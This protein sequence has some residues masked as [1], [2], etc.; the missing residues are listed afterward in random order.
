MQEKHLKTLGIVLI[1]IGLAMLLYTFFQAY[2]LLKSP[3]PSPALPEVSS[4]SAGVP[5]V[6]RAIS[7][8]LLPFFSSIIQSIYSTGYLFIMGL[9]G[10]WILG[11]GIQ[12]V[13]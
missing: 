5:D 8:A 10:Y 7:Q 12:L 9:I 4:G 1:A 3:Y 2:S 6:N 11:R 13:K